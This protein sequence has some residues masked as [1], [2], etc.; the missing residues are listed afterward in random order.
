VNGV[1][2]CLAYGANRFLNIVDGVDRE[3]INGD[4]ESTT[5]AATPAGNEGGGCCHLGGTETGMIL[6]SVGDEVKASG[7]VEARVRDRCVKKMDQTSEYRTLRSV[8]V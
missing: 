5:N 1:A 2:Y 8:E 4:K 6:I 7:R 3:A